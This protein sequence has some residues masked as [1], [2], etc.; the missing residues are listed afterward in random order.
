MTR[1]AL[2]SLAGRKF[3]TVLTALAIVLGVA[4]IS[5]T[6]VLTDTIDKAFSSIFDDSYA[7]TDVVVSGKAADIDIFGDTP[8]A[9]PVDAPLLDEIRGVGSVDLAMGGIYDEVNTKII[10]DDG[11]ALNTNGA[12]SFGFGIDTTPE[13]AVFNPLNLLEGRWPQTGGEVVV[14]AGTADREDFAVGETIEISTL[15]PKQEFEVV[16]I[17]QYGDVKSLG[18]ATF[19]IFDIATAQGLFERQ[20]QFDAISVAGKD[21]VTPQQ[22]ID[23]IQ[24]LLPADAQVKTGVQ[25]AQEDKDDISEFTTFIRYFLLAFAGIALFVG[26][27]VIFNTLSITVAQRTREFAT[28]RTLGASRRQVC[29]RCSSRP[30]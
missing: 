14:D 3:R 8:D 24:P 29:G 2:K 18:T 4:M 13:Y 26:S 21:G 22:L 23:E 20:G 25:E 11:K 10:G 5:G 30:S 27:F 16:G 1:F 28:L 17:A 7:G 19:A 6:Y 12:P 15:K 9:P